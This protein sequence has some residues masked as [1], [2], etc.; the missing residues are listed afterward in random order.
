MDPKRFSLWAGSGG[1][2]AMD[3]V[4]RFLEEA[5]E[6]TLSECEE[7]GSFL[8]HLAGYLHALIVL[9]E[10]VGGYAVTHRDVNL[11]ELRT[12]AAYSRLQEERPIPL[13]E[14]EDQRAFLLSLFGRLKALAPKD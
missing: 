7:E 1:F 10:G 8:A 6:E 4:V 2:S 11:W 5:I 12:M 3:D 14:A 13:E 9:G